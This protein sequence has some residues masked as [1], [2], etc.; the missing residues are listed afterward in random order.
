[1]IQSGFFHHIYHIGCA[2]NLHS[3]INNGLIL[4]GQNSSK[5]Q[6]V[7]FLPIEPRDKEHQDPEKIDLTVP[8]CAQ[9]L[10]SAWKKH[11]D[12][13]FWV[14]IDL[15]IR[16]GLTFYQT[17]S[18]AKILQ[19]TLPAYCIPKVV[20]LKTGEV[21]FEKSYMSPRPPP[22]ILSRHDHD[23][24]RGEVPLGSTVDQQPEGKVVRQSRGEVQ[25]A[26]F[27][28]LTQPIPKP[29]CDRS[30]QLDN[31]QDVFV[32]KGETSRSHEINEKGFHGELCSSDRSGQLDITPSVIKAHNLSE[33]IRVEQTHDRS[34]QPDER[35]SSKAH[36]IKRQDAPEVHRELALLNT[37]N[38]F[39]REIIKE[40]MDFKIPG[41]PHSI[42]KQLQSASVRELIQNI[43][44][45]PNRHAL[46][47]DLQQNQSFNP[48]S[49]ESKQMIHEVGNIELCELL[50]TEPKTQ[51][52]VCLSY[53]DIGIVY[54]TCGHLLRKG[55]VENQTFIKYTMDLLS[56]PE[57]VIKKG[58][59]HGHRYG[60]KPGDREYCTA[61][62]LKKKC[63]KKF[64]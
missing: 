4:G 5:R 28:Q 22:K 57:Y 34:G 3:I 26:T 12:A 24:T 25:H 46:Q 33:N 27:S 50:D 43:E 45:H 8:R 14:D 29:I 21:L 44:N 56:I 6:T 42:V 63:K 19:G 60:K 2:F 38:D 17:R 47:R 20:K 36:T 23:W 18:N 40:D 62:K 41:L 35:N 64:F 10:H 58:R 39:N 59:P 52:K 53:W 31:K 37:D 7:F 13:V 15:A 30:G 48:F 51:C 16:K 32:V 11:Q 9:Y 61:N 54:C 1:M 49:P 55:R